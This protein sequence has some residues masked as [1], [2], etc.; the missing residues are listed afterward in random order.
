MPLVAF[1][2]I[3]GAFWITLFVPPVIAGVVVWRATTP[4]TLL[5][6]WAYGVTSYGL[7]F[8]VLVAALIFSMWL[9]FQRW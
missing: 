3:G 6:F 9:P 2:I 5:S 4:E 8:I 7:L 1:K